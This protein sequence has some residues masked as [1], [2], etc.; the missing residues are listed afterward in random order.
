[1]AGNSQIVDSWDSTAPI[2]DDWSASAQSSAPASPTASNVNQGT[3]SSAPASLDI[4]PWETPTQAVTDALS[5]K[6]H[7]LYSD[8]PVHPNMGLLHKGTLQVAPWETANDAA[9]NAET[10]YENQGPLHKAAGAAESFISSLGSGMMTIPFSGKD[11]SKGLD[12][13]QDMAHDAGVSSQTGP[14]VEAIDAATQQLHPTAAK[15]GGVVGD[16]LDT[17]ALGEGTLKGMDLAGKMAVDPAFL[18][19]AGQWGYGLGT[20]AKALGS[21]TWKVAK[22]PI[23]ALGGGALWEAGGQIEEKA[24]N[25]ITNSP[26]TKPMVDYVSSFLPPSGENK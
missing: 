22:W 16:V 6:N 9:V 3:T 14:D 8:D 24:K 17:A 5:Q 25:Y 18:K 4:A 10:N 15:I 2:T 13:M 11:Y 19:V 23:V 26:F 7:V 1:M 21:A 12:M 20:A